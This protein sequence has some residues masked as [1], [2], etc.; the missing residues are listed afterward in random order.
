LEIRFIKPWRGW[1]VASIVDFPDEQAKFLAEEG[2]ATILEFPKN[3]T[4]ETPKK[5]NIGRPKKDK[6]IRKA[7]KQKTM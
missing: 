1:E 6:M 4:K 7:P 2:I 3:E 5:K